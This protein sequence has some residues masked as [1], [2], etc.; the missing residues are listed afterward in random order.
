MDSE[1][2]HRAIVVIS[3]ADAQALPTEILQRLNGY[4]LKRRF[5]RDEGVYRYS[6]IVDIYETIRQQLPVDN[7]V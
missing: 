2:A 4:Y 3:A 7:N 6:T 1:I 5:A